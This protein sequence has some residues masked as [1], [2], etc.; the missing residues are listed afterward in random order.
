MRKCLIVAVVLVIVV[1]GF[2]AN[3]RKGIM[4]APLHS[5]R[6][7]HTGSINHE[8]SHDDVIAKHS[9]THKH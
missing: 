4:E 9:H 3:S 1:L 6:H 8:H 5:H 7:V 2:R